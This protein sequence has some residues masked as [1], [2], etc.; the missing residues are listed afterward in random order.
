[1]SIEEDRAMIKAIETRYKGYRF[2]SRLEA[3][4]A[5]FFDAFQV[6]WV[7]EEQGYNLG[8]A[9]LY[10]PDFRLPTYDT[11]IEIKPDEP[12]LQEFDK[13]RELARQAN[14]V[15]WMVCGT[16]GDEKIWIV[17]PKGIL[18]PELTGNYPIWCDFF[19]LHSPRIC[20]TVCDKT[21]QGYAFARSARFEHGERG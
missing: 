5:V 20:K 19:Q 1:M 3:R 13:A 2:R 17:E 12:S 18:T 14:G 4:W 21:H 11:W 15:V 8:S 16:P 9:G 7:Y 10:L 6:K